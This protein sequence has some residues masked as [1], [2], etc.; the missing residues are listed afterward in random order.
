MSGRHNPWCIWGHHAP[1]IS[2]FDVI[3]VYDLVDFIL[4]IANLKEVPRTG[5]SLAGLTCHRSESVAEHTWSMSTI[6]LILGHTLKKKL[7]LDLERILIMA[8]IHDFPEVKTSDIP[9]LATRLGG[10]EMERGKSE[11]EHRAMDL[12]MKPI[13]NSDEF[14]E[15][16]KEYEQGETMESRI[17]RGADRLDILIRVIRLESM[18]VSPLN[19]DHFFENSKNE[20]IGLDI[21]EILEIYEILEQKH[22]G[23]K[24]KWQ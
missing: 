6:S 24:R 23:H 8:L 14:L 22:E 7:K 12:L 20:I 4:L 16:W 21:P 18:G 9:R 2:I 10:A 15:I 11:A 3:N 5:W 13:E 1:V 17:V 19:L